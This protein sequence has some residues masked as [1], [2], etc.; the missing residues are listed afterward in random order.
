ML[1]T[2]ITRYFLGLGFVLLGWFMPKHA[3]AGEF[4]AS[5]S[6]QAPGLSGVD[7]TLF[8]NM[9]RDLTEYLNNTRFTEYVFEP[10]ERLMIRVNIVFQRMPASDRFEGNATFQ[11]F[12]PVYG[13]NYE[14]LLYNFDDKFFNVRYVQFQQ[15][16]FSENTFVDNLTS[17]LNFHM[18]MMLGFDFE[19][20]QAGTGAQFFERARNIANLATN[21]GEAGWTPMDGNTVR[22]WVM[23]NMLNNSYKAMQEIY[24]KYHRQG[25]D[26]MATDVAGG[27][28]A[29][30]ECLDK[31]QNLFVQNPNIYIIRVFLDTKRGELINIFKGAFADDKQKFVRMMAVVDARNTDKYNKVLEEK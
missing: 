24:Y 12:R 26:Q 5:V 27:R 1:R 29:I 7:P 8:Q 2:R 6:I 22:F 21:S 13:S 11:L 20:M 10:F 18:Y 25:L 9:Q 23:E 14:T 3:Q 30:M 19:A 16:Q 31:L 4:M 17:L 28:Q 15:L